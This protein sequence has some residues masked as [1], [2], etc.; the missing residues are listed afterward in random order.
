MG[1]SKHFLVFAYALLM[2]IS[3]CGAQMA[4]SKVTGEQEGSSDSEHAGLPLIF[5]VSGGF[6]GQIES[7]EITTQGVAV[8]TNKRSLATINQKLDPLTIGQLR[9]ALSLV[10]G[11]EGVS[12]GQR[13]IGGCSDCLEYRLSIR[14]NGKSR[15]ILVHSNRLVDSNYKELIGMLLS[16]YN[17]IKH[18]GVG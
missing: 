15:N 14:I 10:D 16:I 9:I 3:A 5:I 4:D 11:E 7:L 1:M 12:S 8:L 2:G 17:D 13:I 18:K 6:A